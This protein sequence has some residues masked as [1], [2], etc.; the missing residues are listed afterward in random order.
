MDESMS[1]AER[2]L[3]FVYHM[4]LTVGYNKHI[5]VGIYIIACHLILGI[6]INM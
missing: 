6:I 5:T 1:Y 4:I 2:L 3:A